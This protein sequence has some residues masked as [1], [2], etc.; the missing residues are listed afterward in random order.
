M[1]PVA[2]PVAEASRIRIGAAVTVL[3]HGSAV[4]VAGCGVMI[5]G[6]SGSGKSGL[7]L[8]MIGLGARLVADDQVALTRAG[9]AVLAEAPAPLAGLIEARGVGLLRVVPSGPVPIGL[10]VDLGRSPA[11]RM[12]QGR[13]ITLLGVEVE[14]ILGLGVHNLEAIL[15]ILAQ[16]GPRPV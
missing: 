1:R 5:L 12:P 7:A 4:A 10:A 9:N 2:G 8:R 16:N 15:T 6:P 3:R 14:L 13:E 11:A